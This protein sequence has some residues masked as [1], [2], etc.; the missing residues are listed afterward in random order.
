[1]RELI[2]IF[3]DPGDV[4]ID[5]VAGSGITLL[6]AEQLGRES[7]G[8]EIKKEY[9]KKFDDVFAK[10]IQQSLIAYSNELSAAAEMEKRQMQLVL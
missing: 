10:N 4:V 5:P 6:A 7:Y 9:C 1:M 3:T 8:F 2:T